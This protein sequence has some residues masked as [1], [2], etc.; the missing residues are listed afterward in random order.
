MNFFE[1]N[2]FFI[3]EKVKLLQ[4]ENEYKVYNDNAEYIGSIKQKLSGGDKFLRLVL[5]KS[6]LPFHLE[7]RNAQDQL[8]ASISRGW[9][10]FLSKIVIADSQ[11]FPVGRVEQKFTLMKPQFKIFDNNSNQIGGISGDWRAWNFVITDASGQQIGTISKKWA[12]V[13][14]ELFTTADKYNVQLNAVNIS[15][16]QK[17]AILASAITIDMVLKES[18]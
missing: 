7:I 3:D 12:G 10:F 17:M 13:A 16:E 4:F 14:K 6:M 18:K 15:K 8:E 1:T 11:S 2:S 9:T 5:N